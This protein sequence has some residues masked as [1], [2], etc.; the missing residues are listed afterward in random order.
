MGE[1]T[2]VR[3][4]RRIFYRKFAPVPDAP[5]YR[6]VPSCF[7]FWIFYVDTHVVLYNDVFIIFLFIYRLSK[8]EE[9]VPVINGARS[10]M[11]CG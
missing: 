9:K 11:F 8:N 3:R 7:M 2:G 1:E 4:R 5:L 10:F 6:T